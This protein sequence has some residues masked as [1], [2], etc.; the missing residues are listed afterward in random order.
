MPL[1]L[2]QRMKEGVL[3]RAPLFG[4]IKEVTRKILTEEGIPRPDVVAGGFPCVDICRAGRRRG[5]DGEC[6]SLFYEMTRIAA[7][8]EPPVPYLWFENVGNIVDQSMKK[9][10][11]KIL[12]HLH[13]LGYDG[14]W[15]CIKVSNVAG[16][17][18]R[19]RWFLICTHCSA[20]GTCPLPCPG[21]K[22]F[23]AKDLM[24][25]VTKGCEHFKPFNSMPPPHCRMIHK[26]QYPEVEER[27]GPGD[28]CCAFALW[29]L[30]SSSI[31][32]VFFSK[33][34]MPWWP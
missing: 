7:E 15:L 17:C 3:H 32:C 11:E 4:E 27:A 28:N 1:V 18:V 23:E 29:Y 26:G 21:E 2:E 22:V 30:Q 19:K 25:L 24:E 13:E 10:W 5:L 8:Y 6:S 34:W 20:H 31:D 16:P 14:K 12:R 33:P 9:V